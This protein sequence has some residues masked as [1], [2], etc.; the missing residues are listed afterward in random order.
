MSMSIHEIPAAEAPLELLLLAD[1]SEEKL[2]SYLPSS[3]C[4]VAVCDGVTVGACVLQPRADGIV[5]LMSIAVSEDFQKA[6]IGA[7]LLRWVIDFYRDL[8]TKAIEV[9]TGAFGYQLA[10]YQRHGFRV[11]RIDH[12]FF[13]N[14]YP[15]PIVENGI[16]HFDM[17][18]LTLRLRE[19][20]RAAPPRRP[21]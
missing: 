15:A 9:G 18:R 17:L 7:R 12:D 2:R 4:F 6:G 10:F 20:S 13:I 21:A 14:N 8:G 11:T 16:Q 19:A 5:E 3:R 1:P